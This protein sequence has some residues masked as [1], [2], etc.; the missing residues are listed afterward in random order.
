MD[1]GLDLQ[2]AD[3]SLKMFL[4]KSVGSADAPLWD[5]LPYMYAIAFHSNIWKEA[6]YKSVVEGKFVAAEIA[7]DFP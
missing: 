1:L 7:F 5:L 2:T 4:R 6:V 3:Q